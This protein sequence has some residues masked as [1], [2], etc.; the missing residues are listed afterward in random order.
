MH[1]GLGRMF[2][3]HMVEVWIENVSAIA[4]TQLAVELTSGNVTLHSKPFLVQVFGPPPPA[5][6]PGFHDPL[7]NMPTIHD[8]MNRDPFAFNVDQ[9]QPGQLLRYVCGDFRQARSHVIHIAV[10][11]EETTRAKAQIQARITCANMKGEA[12]ER[13]VLPVRTLRS[14]LSRI[15]SDKKPL[16]MIIPPVYDILRKT[17]EMRIYRND[18][19]GYE[20]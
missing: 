12:T 16:L 20:P 9:G 4:A 18:G 8:L 7:R 15:V 11:V 6:R 10:E 2:S 13:V 1:L 14:R 19:S 3:Q 17:E 5:A